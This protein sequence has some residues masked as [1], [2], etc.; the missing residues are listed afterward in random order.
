MHRCHDT[1]LAR[2]LAQPAN[3]DY[4]AFTDTCGPRAATHLLEYQLEQADS[5]ALLDSGM[6][7]LYGK[8][9]PHADAELTITLLKQLGQLWRTNPPALLD[10]VRAYGSPCLAAHLHMAV[11]QD[12][13]YEREAAPELAAAEQDSFQVR[14]V[15]S[16]F[17]GERLKAL[18]LSE[19]QQQYY[20]DS[21]VPA[22]AAYFGK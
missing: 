20:L 14:A 19:G 11:L 16:G 21:V 9:C 2:V 5:T 6:I 1:D 15:D 17:V 12:L 8:L 3:F 4:R 13:Y 22:H 7:T 18:A 10:T